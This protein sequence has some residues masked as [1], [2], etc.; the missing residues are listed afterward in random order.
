M[1]IL[2]YTKPKPVQRQSIMTAGRED[3]QRAAIAAGSAEG[4]DA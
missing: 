2:A 3:W 1:S 4:N